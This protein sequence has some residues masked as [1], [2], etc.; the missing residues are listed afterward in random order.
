[1]P[2]YNTT[3]FDPPAPLAQ[4]T[5]RNPA[6]GELL[7]DVPMLLDTGSDVTLIS[8]SVANQF[9]LNTIPDKRYELIG[10]DGSLSFASV[11]W[12]EMIF[13]ERTFRGLFLIVERE[14]GVIGR[15]ILNLVPLLLDGPNLTW[16][17]Q[18]RIR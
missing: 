17:I 14:Y 3:L 15:N 11:T 13:L 2:A 1:M 12:V 16:S 9:G 7:S 10:F 4:V 8:T 5:L 6:T 18:R